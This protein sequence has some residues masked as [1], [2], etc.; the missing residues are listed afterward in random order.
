[1]RLTRVCGV[2][3]KLEK[4]GIDTSGVDFAGWWKEW[5]AAERKAKA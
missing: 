4:L 3:R 1:M 2:Q 5:I